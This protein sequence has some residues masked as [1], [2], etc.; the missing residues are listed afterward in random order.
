RRRARPSGP[1]RAARPGCP[2]LPG[3]LPVPALPAA[4]LPPFRLLCSRPSHPAYAPIG[5]GRLP[6]PAVWR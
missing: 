3:R 4:L 6:K 5:A 2:L 1:A